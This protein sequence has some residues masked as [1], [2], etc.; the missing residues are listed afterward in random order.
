MQFNQPPATCAQ[1]QNESQYHGY[2]NSSEDEF[3]AKENSRLEIS[4][5]NKEIERLRLVNI[6]KDD[7]IEARN[8]KIADLE[9]RVRELE[10][11]VDNL[12]FEIVSITRKL[13]ASRESTML[14]GAD[15]HP[16]GPQQPVTPFD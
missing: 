15:Q 5:L 1:Q 14:N 7:E 12:N 6:Y 10:A 3:R 8:Q 9:A 16:Q 11:K 13:Q 2:Q 4:K